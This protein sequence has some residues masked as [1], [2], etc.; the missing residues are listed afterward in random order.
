MAISGSAVDNTYSI[1]FIVTNTGMDLLNPTSWE[2]IGYPSLTSEF[3]PGYYGTGHN[4]VTSDEYGQ[5]LNVY[6]ARPVDGGR[7]ST[8]RI[9]HFSVDGTPVLDMTPER[10]ILPENRLVS[11]KIIVKDR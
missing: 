5:V 8:L 4:S 7:S 6:H 3:V 9:V 1:G 10:E 11:A 2:R